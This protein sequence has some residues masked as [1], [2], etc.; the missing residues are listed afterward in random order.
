MNHAL[1][2]SSI[3]LYFARNYKRTYEQIFLIN[4]NDDDK[5]ST[6]S[7]TSANNSNYFRFGWLLFL[8]LRLHVFRFK[9]LVTSTNGLISV[10]VSGYALCTSETSLLNS[11]KDVKITSL[12]T[13][14]AINMKTKIAHYFML[15]I[16]CL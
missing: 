4:D 16:S 14:A 1:R 13:W 8:E 9:D 3:C 5:H 2:Y 10:L 15:K 12:C 7:S 6:V 11:Q